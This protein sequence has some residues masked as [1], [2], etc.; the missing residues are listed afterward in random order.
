MYNCICEGGDTDS[1]FKY[2]QE[3]KTIQKQGTGNIYCFA[4]LFVVYVQGDI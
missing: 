1:L 3:Q 4:C 2:V